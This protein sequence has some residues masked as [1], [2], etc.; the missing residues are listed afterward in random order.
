MNYVIRFFSKPIFSDKRFLLFI[1]IGL[2]VLSA[3]KTSSIDN[4]YLIYKG[5]FRH[6]IEQVNLY[7]EYPEQYYD[8][9]HYGPIFGLLIA[10]FTYLKEPF[11]PIMWGIVMNLSLFI[12]IYYLPIPW[13]LKVLIYY[14]P[15]HELFICVAN[16]QINTLITAFIIGSF[17]FIRKEKDFWAAC[18][19]ALGVFIKLY[20]IVGFCFFFFSKNKL[21]LI[22]YFIFWSIIFFVL[23]MIISSPE[24]IL[25]TYQD[26]YQ[27]LVAKNVEN[28]TSFTQDISAI[29]MIRRTF[30][31]MDASVLYILVPALA[32]FALQYLKFSE[33]N[34]LT[35]QLAILASTLLFLVLFS[36]GSESP[37][38]I[39]AMVGVAIWFCIQERPYNKWIIALL[40]FAIIWTT[41][42]TS[43]ILPRS[44]RVEVVR[45]YSLKAFPSLI[46]WLVLLYQLLR[47]KGLSNK[48]ETDEA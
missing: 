21:K 41:L 13:K 9:N 36:T 4:N 42:A 12:A 25:Q 34:K 47:S 17:I 7:L 32:L 11:G 45:R 46:V 27:S 2:A 37:T 24:F 28:A 5:V 48:I 8:S 20:G 16:S 26:W 23:P 30:D 19:I 38:Y 29:G 35:Y 39:I 3:L 22:G 15:L 1:W 14:I 44:F 31:C 10:P 18:L 43:D 33:Y 40:F 6:L